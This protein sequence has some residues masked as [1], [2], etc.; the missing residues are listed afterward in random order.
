MLTDISYKNYKKQNDIHGTVLCPAVMVAPVQKDVLGELSR[1]KLDSVFDPFHGSF[2]ALYESFDVFQNARIIGCDIN[3]I[4]NLITK[5]KLQG[6]SGEI[7][8]SIYGVQGDYLK[9]NGMI[10]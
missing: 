1:E 3:P 2:T 7:A 6:I 5:I 4:A 10:P 8:E 9:T